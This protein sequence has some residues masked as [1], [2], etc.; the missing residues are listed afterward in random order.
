MISPFITFTPSS[1]ITPSLFILDLK[2]IFSTIN[3]SHHKNWYTY[4]TASHGLSDL[5]LIFYARR[6]LF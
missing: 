2:P 6:F 4:R 1:S 3:P 5:F